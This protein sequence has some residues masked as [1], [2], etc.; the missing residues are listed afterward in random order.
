M[1]VTLL[2]K[3]LIYTKLKDFKLANVFADKAMEIGYKINDRLSIADIFKI[4]GIIESNLNNYEIAENHLNTSLRINVE[5]ENMLNQAETLFE[6]GLLYK[7]MKDI[8]KS[9]A[10]F[11]KSLKLFSDL[12]IINKIKEVKEE[13]NS[14]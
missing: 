8:K 9:R 13:L 3:A 6:F 7:K 11:R 5:L 4:K 10:D 2:S 12:K 14:L 1:C